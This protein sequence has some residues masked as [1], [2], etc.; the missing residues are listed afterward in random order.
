MPDTDNPVDLC[1]LRLLRDCAP[2]LSR[3]LGRSAKKI[4]ADDLACPDFGVDS[5]R[6]NLDDGSHCDFN[7]AFHLVDTTRCIIAVF[8]EHCGYHQFPL[9]YT[10]IDILPNFPSPDDENKN[11]N[12]AAA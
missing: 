7:Y 4:I 3:K 9:P 11:S 10:T 8:T 12:D 5:V 2:Q 1:D 6:V